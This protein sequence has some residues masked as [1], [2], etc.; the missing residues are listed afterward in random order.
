[1][2]L[3]ANL[4]PFENTDLRLRGEYVHQTIA[5]P[6]SNLTVTSATEAAFPDHFVRDDTGQLIAADLRP[7]NFQSS[8]RDT[9]RIGFD[10][11]KPLKSHQ[12]SQAVM[13][14]MRAQFGGRARD[15][16]A[17]GS[18][19]ENSPPPSAPPGG[20]S[21]PA[22]GT[23]AGAP[24]ENAPASDGGNGYR[25]G[26]RFG[27]RGGGGFFGGGNRGRLTFSLTD[28]I[29][30]VDKVEIAPGFNLDYRH[31]DA[32]GEDG[33]T[34]RHQVEAQAGY[35]N[36]GLGARLV[37]NLRSGTSVNTLTGDNLRFSPLATFDL[38]LFANP[39]DMPE[40]A[41]KHPWLR[42]TQVQLRVD[43]IMNNRP[44]VHDFNGNVPLNYQPDLLDPLG[45]TIMISF[46]KLFL[47]IPSWFRR[48]FQEM[49]QGRPSS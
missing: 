8:E 30:F 13:D 48:Q 27:G 14:Q 11:T 22:A 23:Q 17:G 44:Q 40:V 18:Q 42:G 41:V 26:G 15:R 49:R 37:G 12:P 45:R 43:N 31:G 6:I 3:G 4:Q 7:V 28:T 38:R 20:A 16:S 24:P 9:L 10:F 32:S 2:K 33:G 46:R 35:F 25:G 47:P 1:M 19:Q 5:R 36:N 34:P 21:P 29:T 39:G